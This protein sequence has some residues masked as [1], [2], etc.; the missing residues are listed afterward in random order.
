[1]R[2]SMLLNKFYYSDILLMIVNSFC[3][4]KSMAFYRGK[5][6]HD[7]KTELQAIIEREASSTSKLDFIGRFQILKSPAFLRPFISV[8]VTFILLNMS[9]MVI[10]IGP[11]SATFL[12][13]R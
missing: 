10:I 2:Q 6:N 5:E 7:Q 9:C 8:T 4:R 3:L 11:Y 12:E 1:M 13:A